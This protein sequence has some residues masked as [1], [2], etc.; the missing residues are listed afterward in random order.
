[1][2]FCLILLGITRHLK[3]A[4]QQ[5]PL[6]FSQTNFLIGEFNVAARWICIDITW[7]KWLD[8]ENYSFKNYPFIIYPLIFSYLLNVDQ[9]Q[10]IAEDVQAVPRFY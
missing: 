7:L 10:D 5:P 1:M 4:V 6:M 8:L 9:V 2:L 3:S